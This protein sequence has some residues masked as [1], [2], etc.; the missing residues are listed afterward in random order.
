MHKIYGVL[1]KV[2]TRSQK[3]VKF[4]YL[5]ISSSH[6]LIISSSRHLI[7]LH[8]K[9]IC[10]CMCYQSSTTRSYLARRWNLIHFQSNRWYIFDFNEVV[11]FDDRLETI[12]VQ[13]LHVINGLWLI[14]NNQNHIHDAM[15]LW[16]YDGM[17][18]W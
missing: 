10:A 8:L 17:M 12:L 11:T 13:Q 16:C 2:D 14:A 4:H 15:M 3:C 5:I 6:H 18:L 9:T 7:L 1:S